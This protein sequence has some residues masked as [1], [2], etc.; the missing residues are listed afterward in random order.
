MQNLWMSWEI[1]TNPKTNWKDGRE[2]GAEIGKYQALNMANK[3]A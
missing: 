2:D 1:H 3:I